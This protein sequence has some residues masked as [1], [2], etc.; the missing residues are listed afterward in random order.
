MASMN[1][2]GM[3]W[4]GKNIEQKIFCWGLDFQV[5]N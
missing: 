2:A 5:I 4:T 1:I 3:Q